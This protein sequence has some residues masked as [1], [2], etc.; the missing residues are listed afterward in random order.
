MI[1]LCYSIQRSLMP[2]LQTTMEDLHLSRKTVLEKR[3][4]GLG[5]MQL[6]EM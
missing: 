3:K 4:G 1:R 2:S 5:F 6:F